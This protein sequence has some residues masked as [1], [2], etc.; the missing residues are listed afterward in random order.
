MLIDDC[1]MIPQRK[2]LVVLVLLF[3]ALGVGLTFRTA[4]GA[5]ISIL[6]SKLSAPR[7]VAERLKQYGTN[8]RQ[9]NKPHFA[10]AGVAYPPKQLVLFGTKDIRQLQVYAANA[11]GK[12]RKSTRL[13]SSHRL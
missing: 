13:N 6:K 11:D 12:D 8:A 7:T 10:R 9:R 2:S 4:I 1:M 3:V 5:G